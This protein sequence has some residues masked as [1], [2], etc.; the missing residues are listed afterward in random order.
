[1]GL[2]SIQSALHPSCDVEPGIGRRI[3]LRRAAGR[4]QFRLLGHGGASPSE[5]PSSECGPERVEKSWEPSRLR[6]LVWSVLVGATLPSLASG[7]SMQADEDL[8]TS[9]QATTIRGY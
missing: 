4:N 3:T 7:C 9:S 5:R 1:V 2:V 6:A 8:A